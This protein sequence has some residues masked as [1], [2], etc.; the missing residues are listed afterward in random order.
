MV[1]V[2]YEFFGESHQTLGIT[3]SSTAR[4]IAGCIHG[5]FVL[6]VDTYSIIYH[7]DFRKWEAIPEIGLF[8]SIPQTAPSLPLSTLSYADMYSFCP[9]PLEN[10][11]YV[12]IGNILGRELSVLR[13][14]RAGWRDRPRA[15]LVDN[16]GDISYAA[17]LPLPKEHLSNFLERVVSTNVK[18]KWGSQIYRD[19]LLKLASLGI[20]EIEDLKDKAK[21]QGFEKSNYPFPPYV[22][23]SIMLAYKEEKA[24]SQMCFAATELPI[25]PKSPLAAAAA[26]AAV[27]HGKKNS[28]SKPSSSS[29]STHS[30]SASK[31]KDKPLTFRSKVK[32]SG[33][34]QAPKVTTLFTRPSAKNKGTTTANNKKSLSAVTTMN[35]HS[36]SNLPPSSVVPHSETWSHSAP[37][38]YLKYHPLGNCFATCSSDRSARIYKNLGGSKPASV[39]DFNGHDSPVNELAL[40]QRHT[41]GIGYL[42]MTGSG[43]GLVK[44]W[45]SELSEPILTLGCESPAAAKGNS[46]SLSSSS[47]LPVR[48]SGM[49]NTMTTT[50]ST[51]S[52]SS[53]TS[54]RIGSMRFFN[55]DALLVLSRGPDLALC[56]YSVEKPDPASIK[57]AL[58]GLY[59]KYRVVGTYKSPPPKDSSFYSPSITSLA[60]VNTI[61]SHIVITATSDKSL[62]VWNV[63]VGKLVSSYPGAM[64]RSIHTIAVADYYLSS[65]N[66]VST[67]NNNY[68]A[69]DTD[70][71]EYNNN[72]AELG[73]SLGMGSG[74]ENLLVT[75]ALTDSIKLWD[76]R[77]LKPVL[78]LHGHVNRLCSVGV[79]LSPCGKY[80][81][82]GSEVF[83]RE[84]GI[85]GRCVPPGLI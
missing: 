4:L 3:S 10:S 35:H 55:H 60:C 42:M 47:S 62:N 26:G 78:H 40:S 50:S 77:T 70:A 41:K 53:G 6:D 11:V 79:A 52:G 18:G 48:L 56:T 19:C 51:S 22:S 21:V 84:R 31:S 38:M 68:D 67:S 66:G 64:K 49:M 9:A 34:T 7:L 73:L 25:N 1:A 32:S 36:T 54:K 8:K 15:K 74:V 80:I 28:P 33:Y 30:S 69:E 39:K 76:I 12:I 17:Q 71:E 46:S 85:R 45:G 2:K 37:V 5:I 43:D 83:K 59:N 75:A 23:A 16:A 20:T 72:S 14:S 57:P 82:S 63:N 29:S 27:A 58:Q 13:L 65:S 81:V 44:M 61:R 24:A